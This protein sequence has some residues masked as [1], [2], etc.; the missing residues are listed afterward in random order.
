MA[1]L[2]VIFLLQVKFDPKA[3]T[4]LFPF[5]R[6]G[7]FFSLLIKSNSLNAISV[8]DRKR[9]KTVLSQMQI[10]GTSVSQMSLNYV[11]NKIFRAMRYF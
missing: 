5:C 1:H 2:P 10:K 4:D 7:S 9:I 3:Q 8:Y 11:H 6:N